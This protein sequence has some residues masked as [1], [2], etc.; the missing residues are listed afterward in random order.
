M[1]ATPSKSTPKRSPAGRAP[2]VARRSPS[3]ARAQDTVDALLIATKTLLIRGGVEAATTNA[4]AKLA[5]VSI[6]S[7]Y[8]YF[9][10]REALIAELS[11]RHVA[12]VLRLLFGEIDALLGTSIHVGARRLIK[13]MIDIHRQDPE[14]HAAIE[15]SHPGLGARAQLMQMDEQV[16]SMA[17]AYLER[18]R[19]ELVVTDLD[20]ASFVVVTT[21]EALTHDAC[22]KRPD[23]LE[24]DAMVDDITRLILGY[25]TDP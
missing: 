20:R 24:N 5:G 7:L 23:L 14:L 3:Q 8:Q 19:A 16:M 13:L 25:L 9:P 22:L 6:G 4:V 12:S 18:H 11:R 15:A 10:S 21:V 2:T 1:V 17:R